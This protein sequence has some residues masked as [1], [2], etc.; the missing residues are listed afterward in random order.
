MKKSKL[1]EEKKS[2]EEIYKTV[3]DIRSEIQP[4][5]YESNPISNVVP[6]EKKKIVKRSSKN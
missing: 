2:A 1:T 3:N 4:A 5:L 6:L